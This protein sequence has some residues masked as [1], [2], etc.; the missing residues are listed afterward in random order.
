VEA[1]TKLGLELASGDSKVSFGESVDF[2]IDNDGYT[3][4]LIWNEVVLVGT[5]KEPAEIENSESYTVDAV[6]YDVCYFVSAE[7]ACVDPSD[8]ICVETDLVIPNLITPSDGNGK[9]DTFL[10]GTGISVQ[11]FNRYSAL[12]YEGNDGWDATF[13]EEVA[14]PGTYYY[15]ITFKNGEQRKGTLEVAKFK[16]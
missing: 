12:I 16:K 3:E 4:K 1:R 9:N 2:N 11:I 8:T 15:I 13:K 10:K 14:E 7:G 6:E 5:P